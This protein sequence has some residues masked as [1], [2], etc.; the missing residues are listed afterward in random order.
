VI[1]SEQAE[2]LLFS[3]Q[4]Y[5]SGEPSQHPRR[6]PSGGQPLAGRGTGL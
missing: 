5:A 3:G 1:A 2:L 6:D 4:Y